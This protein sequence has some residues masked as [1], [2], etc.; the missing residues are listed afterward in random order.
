MGKPRQC[1]CTML[2]ASP[3]QAKN[4]DSKSGWQMVSS[5]AH[6]RESPTALI[7]HFLLMVL[8]YGS[9]LDNC[10]ASQD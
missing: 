5:I 3:Q 7:Y 8:L 6:S 4:P 10:G 2:D 9:G 1:P